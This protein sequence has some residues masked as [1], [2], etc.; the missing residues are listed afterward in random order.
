MFKEKLKELRL[1]EGLS[2]YDLADKIFVSR[3]TV[4]K[5]ENGLGMPGKAAME[6]LC[7]FF[8]VTKDELLKEDDSIKIIENIEK[9]SNKK[10]KLLI[11]LIIL[12]SG[13]LLISVG[14]KIY[15]DIFPSH[16]E[17]KYYSDSYL[18][19]FNL[20]ELEMMESN[21][22]SL[23]GDAWYNY[24][25][26][27]D[28]YKEYTYYVYD[29]LKNNAKNTNLSFGITLYNEEFKTKNDY[30]IHQYLIESDCIE[31]HIVNINDGKPIEYEF[32]FVS[33]KQTSRNDKENI[34]VNKLSLKYMDGMV[35]MKLCESKHEIFKNQRIMMC[36]YYLLDEYCDI[37]RHNVNNENINNYFEIDKET[38]NIKF[39]AKDS[40][41]SN[42]NY[43]FLNI[44]HLNVK[45]TYSISEIGKQENIRNEER[46]V[47]VDSDGIIK[48]TPTQLGIDDISKYDITIDVDVLENSYYYSIDEFNR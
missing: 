44:L 8:N 27:Y 30:Y 19:R 20:Q 31:E 41:V 47:L 29:L 22:Y 7:S 45:V 37:K 25:C 12:L 9:H 16:M 4:A 1:K 10:I 36:E 34:K 26:S 23:F 35:E 32:Y 46:I 39:N 14:V 5:W 48:I 42:L 15:N 2:Q 24:E 13:F 21:A 28:E 11:L 17:N 33:K 3:S 6:S 43:E 38:I 40:I 18:R